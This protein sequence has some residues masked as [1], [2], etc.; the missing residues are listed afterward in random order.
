MPAGQ[1]Q[2]HEFEPR[3]HKTK[4]VSYTHL[5]A[6]ETRGNEII[7]AIKNNAN[8]YEKPNKATIKKKPRGWRDSS[9]A[10]VPAGQVQGHEF[11][12][13]SRKK[14]ESK[15]RKNLPRTEKSDTNSSQQ[16]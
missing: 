13:W 2:G 8:T 14:K 12:P 3:S 7:A 5:R 4:P 15:K 6:H 1:V 10:Q 11:E 9:E 16:S